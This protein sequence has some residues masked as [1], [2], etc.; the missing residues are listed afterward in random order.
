MRGAFGILTVSIVSMVEQLNEDRQ[1]II[2][3]VVRHQIN[4]DR[5]LIPRS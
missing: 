4:S 1:R 3:P 2:P 5:M